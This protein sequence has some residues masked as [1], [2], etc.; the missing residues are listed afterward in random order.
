MLR[1]SPQDTKWKR[2]IHC[3]VHTE[4]Q[5]YHFLLIESSVFQHYFL[6]WNTLQFLCRHCLLFVAYL[7]L[8]LFDL[9][10]WPLQMT[11][12][13]PCTCTR[14]AELNVTRVCLTY[15]VSRRMNSA[16]R[17]QQSFLICTYVLISLLPCVPPIWRTIDTLPWHHVECEL[18]CAHMSPLL[19]EV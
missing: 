8:F 16:P 15:D 4:I 17:V 18:R 2:N 1:Q 5:P 14:M 7:S 9:S 11:S 3:L 13:S 6:N 19:L 12:R 10:K